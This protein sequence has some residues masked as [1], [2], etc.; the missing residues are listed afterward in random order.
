ML[1]SILLMSRPPL[2]I[3]GGEY[4]RPTFWIEF[5]LIAEA[6]SVSASNRPRGLQKLA[7]RICHML[8]RRSRRLTPDEFQHLES[9]QSRHLDIEKQ[10]VGLEIR[11]SLDLGDLLQMSTELVTK[12]REQLI[13]KI[14]VSARTEP[15]IE[16]GR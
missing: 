11:H 3:Q 7:R 2:L 12:R 9:V 10:Q 6:S 8:L 4:P 16:R 14:G 15:F 1:R 13:L 5:R